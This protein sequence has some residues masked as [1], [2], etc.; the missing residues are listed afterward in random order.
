MGEAEFAGK[1]EDTGGVG[2]VGEADLVDDAHGRS[3]EVVCW[4]FVILVVEAACGVYIV[5]GLR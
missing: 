4:S 1:E 2:A 3:C 5:I